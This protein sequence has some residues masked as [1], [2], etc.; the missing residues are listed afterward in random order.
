MRGAFLRRLKVR[1]FKS[2][3][4]LDVEFG[5][6]NMLV[7]SNASGKSNFAQIF[8]FLSDMRGGLGGALARQGGIECVRNFDGDGRVS[9]GLEIDF[10]PARLPANLSGSRYRLYNTH[11]GW[12]FA[13]EARGR[14]GFKVTSDAWRFHITGVDGKERVDG[15]AYVE[16]RGGKVYVEPDFPAEV[17]DGKALEWYCSLGPRKKKSR[18]SESSLESPAMA[19]LMFPWVGSFFD[20]FAV[21]DFSPKLAKLPSAAGGRRELEADGANLPLVLKGIMSNSEK[22]RKFCNLASDI[23][24]LAESLRVETSAGGYVALMTEERRAGGRRAYAALSD[25]AANLMALV[26]ALHFEDVQLAVIEEPERS[27]HPA[28]LSGMADMMKDASSGRQIIATTH[29]PEIVR[30]SG[31]GNLLLASRR[32]GGS[33]ITRPAKDGEVRS[34]LEVGMDAGEMHVQGMLGD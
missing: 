22:K 26:A 16:Q 21:Y 30:Q 4:E 9:I 19:D 27:V 17:M 15:V 25:G 2:F 24:P 5:E 1:N 20:R 29:S 13:L 18:E 12:N 33:G 31:V 34:F 3:A 8:K 10:P 6:F 32:G 23:L 14:R 7:G 11:A 28:L